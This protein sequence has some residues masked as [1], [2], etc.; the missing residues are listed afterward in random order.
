[1]KWIRLAVVAAAVVALS[2]CNIVIRVGEG[3]S[4]TWNDGRSSCSAG[5]ECIVAVTD[6]LFSEVFVASADSGFEFD[7]WRRRS[8]GLCG[9]SSGP[10][11]LS[12]EN[13]PRNAAI[14]RLLQ[15]DDED[16]FLV[17]EFSPSAGGGGGSGTGNA[18][19]CFNPELLSQG[20]QASIEYRV[21]TPGEPDLNTTW[22][23]VVVGRRN[24]NG[25]SATRIVTQFEVFVDGIRAQAELSAYVQVNQSAKR[26]KQ[27]GT[28]LEASAQ[29]VTLTTVVTHTP[30]SLFRFDLTPGESYQDNY[31]SVVELNSPAFPPGFS[32][33][34]EFRFRDT[35][36]Y[37]GQESVTV[38]AG[39]YRAC[40]WELVSR[41]GGETVTTE[42]WIDVK[43]GVTIR[44]R[45]SDGS[46]LE[47]LR[48]S[49]LNG[50]RI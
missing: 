26:V 20:T 12:T 45:G 29:G 30:Y 28:E 41:G 33:R 40:R 39:T 17:A 42:V 8:R 6:F 13:L 3:G 15:S 38:P 21:S 48:G 1:M 23:Q 18:M 4:V 11:E 36:T 14:R 46:G 19:A 10:C 5:E 7:G 9:G 44:E 27:L 50:S 49:T 31:T 16:F 22:E 32:Q 43:S 34:Q 47:M 24:F 37:L 2:G 25:Q 35:Y